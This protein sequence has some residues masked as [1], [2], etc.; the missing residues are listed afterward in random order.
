MHRCSAQRWRAPAARRTGFIKTAAGRGDTV[1][2][3]AGANTMPDVAALSAYLEGLRAV[4]RRGGA[5]AETAYH[6]QLEQLLNEVGRTLTPSVTCVLTTRNHGAGIPDG[7]LFV[8]CQA[9]TEAGD[10]AL[11]SRAPERGVMEVRGPAQDVTRVAHSAQVLRYLERYGKV[12]VC[13]YRDFLVVRL[14]SSGRPQAG[15]RFTLAADEASFWAL[16]PQRTELARGTDFGGYLNRAL[17]GPELDAS[18]LEVA[19]PDYSPAAQIRIQ[20]GSVLAAPS[21]EIVE[22]ISELER[23]LA[24]D[25]STSVNRV[26]RI[27]RRWETNHFGLVWSESVAIFIGT[28]A[29]S[30]LIGA[31][32]ND[33]YTKAKAWGRDLFNERKQ[34]SV[35]DHIQPVSF[36]IYDADA[37][38]RLLLDWLINGYGEHETDHRGEGEGPDATSSAG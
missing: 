11:L 8:T 17:L 22:S 27:P 19:D 38:D 13:T 12:L 3:A 20:I 6:G 33:V 24:R 30:G 16:D 26:E 7:G 23:N 28:S 10:A 5:I 14:D 9:V 2:R 34:A 15:E 32:V 29:A 25:Y 21:P 18:Y 1:L 37:G 35:D 4:H 36:T 31:M